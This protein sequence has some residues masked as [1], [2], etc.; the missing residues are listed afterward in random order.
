MVDEADDLD[1]LVLHARPADGEGDVEGLK[2]L[3]GRVLVRSNRGDVALAV[4]CRDNGVEKGVDRG[5]IPGLHAVQLQCVRLAIR[6]GQ[7]DAW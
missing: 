3:E 5:Q 6:C 1:D 2:P 4:T 7:P